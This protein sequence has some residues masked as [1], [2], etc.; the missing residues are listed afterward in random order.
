[1]TAVAILGLCFIFVWSMFSSSSSSVTTRIESFDNIGAPPGSRNTRVN[2]PAA[3]SSIK[4]EDEKKFNGSVTLSAH[5]HKSEKKDQKEVAN[6]KKE[7]GGEGALIVSLDQESEE[8]LEDDGSESEERGKKRYKIKVM[9]KLAASICWNI[10]AHKTDEVSD[11]GVKIYQKPDSNDI[12]E[13]RRKK[14][15]PLCKENDN[16][17]AA[18]TGQSG[19]RN[20][21][22]GLKGIPTG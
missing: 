13:L 6:V 11:V 22:R 9:S 20:G 17:D 15:P 8:K 1:M 5:E 19:Q 18:C 21:P 10:L 2:I 7:K 3:Q 4:G 16:P 12:Y 14:Y